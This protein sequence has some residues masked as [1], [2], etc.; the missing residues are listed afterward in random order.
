MEPQALRFWWGEHLSA[1]AQVGSPG[2]GS[3]RFCLLSQ[4]L[5]ERSWSP[6]MFSVCLDP[7]RCETVAQHCPLLVTLRPAALS[8]LGI[9]TSS[10]CSAAET[11]E[12]VSDDCCGFVNVLRWRYAVQ[13]A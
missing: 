6:V 1:V 11:E 12:G 9:E 5:L 10:R 4:K 7:T 13:A 3:F 8:R 2:P